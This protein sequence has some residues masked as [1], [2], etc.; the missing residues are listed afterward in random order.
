MS[1]ALCRLST[2]GGLAARKLYTDADEVVFEM[3]R[4]VVLTGIPDLASRADLA[5]RAVVVH[6]PRMPE[7]LDERTLFRE[8]DVAAPRIL[9]SIMDALASA[10]RR[11]HGVTVAAPPRM[12]DFARWVTAAEVGLGWPEGTILAAY[13]RLQSADCREL[14]VGPRGRPRPA[15]RRPRGRAGLARIRGRAP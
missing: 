14:R 12:A 10:L 11:V 6:L 9:G 13:R 3:L 5:E 1:D 7:R 8:F 15:R 4:P 2:G